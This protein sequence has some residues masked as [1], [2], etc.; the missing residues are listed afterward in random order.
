ML[1]VIGSIT[2]M[3]AVILL[4]SSSGNFNN[5]NFKLQNNKDSLVPVKGQKAGLINSSMQNVRY[6]GKE[7]EL[8]A[9]LYREWKFGTFGFGSIPKGWQDVLYRQPSRN[10]V[11][12]GNGF[13]RH[14][15]KNRD[16][17]D[18]YDPFTDSFKK[19]PTTDT[20][21]GLIAVADSQMPVNIRIKARFRKTEDEEVFFSI[22]GRI[23][24]KQNF[25]AVMLTGANKLV[26]GKVKQDS[27]FAL[28]ELAI[29][30]RYSYPEEW[31]LV[32]SFHNDLITGMLYD[33]KGR[34]QGRLDA[35]DGEFEN[36]SCGIYA[37]D[38][39]AT[40]TYSI[41]NVS[42]KTV[43]PVIAGVPTE[44][45]PLYRYKLLQ[46]DNNPESLNSSI[47]EVDS[48]Y[49]ILISGAGMSGWAAAVQAARMGRKVLL[50]DE[51]DWIGGQTT[52]AAVSSMDESGPLIRERG[53]YRE[54]HESIVSYYYGKDKCPF[55]AYFWGRNAQNQ[56]EG[57][58]EP[59]V[60]RNLLYAFIREAKK[61]PGAKLDLLLRTKVIKLSKTGH[62]V[63]G[64][65][66]RQWNEGGN[67]QSKIIRSKVL[68]DAT[69]YGDVIPLTGEPYR[70]G[71]TKSSERN[72]K[73]ILQD[74]T[75]TAVIREYPGGVPEHLKLKQPPP[76]YDK[77]RKL[78]TGRLISGDWGLNQGPRMYRTEL[79]WRGMADSRSP[80]VGKSSQLRHTITGFNGGNDYPVSVATI[81][82]AQ[83]RLN[84][85]RDGIYRTLAYIYYLQNELNVPWSLAEDQQYNTAYNRE[86]MKRRGI[87]E[88]LLDLVKHLPQI[89][90]VRESRRLEGVVMVVADDLQRG[91]KAKHVAT[92]VAVGDYFMDLHRSYEALEKD[93]DNENYARG[94]GPFQLPFEA[95]IPKK[96]DGFIPAEKNFSQ[97]RLVSGATRLQ[98][99]TML[100]GQAVGTMAAL[101]VEKN[102]QP[103]SLNPL[104]VQLRLLE[105]GSTLIPRWYKDI[106]WGTELW[107]ATQ[108]L[109][110]YKILD[111]RGGLLYHDGMEFGPKENWN[112]TKILTK[113]EAS[114]A[115]GKLATVLGLKSFGKTATE[116]TDVQSFKELHAI[117]AEVNPKLAAL[118]DT[119]ASNKGQPVTHEKFALVCL[120]LIKTKK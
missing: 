42:E 87:P 16:S 22:A 30:N 119:S 83:Q 77:F 61:I 10:W 106:T 35:R 80:M 21:P 25:Y 41:S 86:M 65:H 34:L 9:K 72:L 113:A 75:F 104:A 4:A 40:S 79:A 99:I 56:Q 96:L 64:A 95:F 13:L 33:D 92:S 2:T 45:A 19:S 32:V 93:L 36:G 12:D 76:M 116:Q 100:T 17:K 52:T 109:S 48:E 26:I 57:G 97:S 46:P 23:K 107:Q 82:S 18:A 54:F 101:A 29:L 15:L 120:D 90:Y 43:G 84:D 89:P 28:S 51:T 24:N 94:G 20:R 105:D 47:K 11:I 110:L 117:A 39:V 50:L 67:E 111:K 88:N 38:Y 74:H 69:E 85:E 49:D 63:T 73:G 5:P 103:R 108:L 71:N 37:T 58:Y 55:M 78:Y 62:R 53:I 118:L 14:I 59:L 31:E 112:T 60:A 81:E 66:I 44:S 91:D 7:I 115:L 68:V 102:V 3:S 6:N 1:S 27:L 98:P 114:L 70:V 8:P